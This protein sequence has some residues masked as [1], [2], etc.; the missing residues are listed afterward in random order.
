MAVGW[1]FPQLELVWGEVGRAEWNGAPLPLHL[2]PPATPAQ[3]LGGT[4]PGP[5]GD[6][7]QVHPALPCYPAPATT[8]ASQQLNVATVKKPGLGRVK[9]DP[10]LS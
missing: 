3:V 10:L 8:K 1:A 5:Q 9:G 2:P 7:T 6:G 4:G